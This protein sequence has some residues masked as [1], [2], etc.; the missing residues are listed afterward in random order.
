MTDDKTLRSD[1]L[2]LV[3]ILTE[4]IN[5]YSSIPLFIFCD[6]CPQNMMMKEG[7]WIIFVAGQQG[8]PETGSS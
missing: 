3:L 8:G 2:F 1:I 7:I 5:I 6:I 4:Y